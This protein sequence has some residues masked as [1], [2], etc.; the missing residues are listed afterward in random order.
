MKGPSR[1]HGCSE[2]T[3]PC[4]RAVI[5]GTAYRAAGRNHFTRNRH[6]VIY[7]QTTNSHPLAIGKFSLKTPIHAPHNGGFFLGDLTSRKWAALGYQ[8][9]CQE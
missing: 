6:K 5:T 4:S 9:H 8:Q 1:V 7:M 3:Y 2:H